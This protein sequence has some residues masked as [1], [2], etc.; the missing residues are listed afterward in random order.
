MFHIVEKGDTLRSIAERYGST[1][2]AMVA[3]NPALTDPDRIRPG[4]RLAIPD[5]DVAPPEPEA[6][7]SASAGTS[8]RTP[9]PA[10]PGSSAAGVRRGQPYTIEPGD[11]LGAIASRSGIDL[12]ELLIANPDI[13]DPDLV[14]PGQV[15]VIPRT[16]SA[17]SDAAD[18]GAPEAEPVAPR[19][20]TAHGGG[21]DW[22]RVPVEQRMLYAM[23]RLVGY[24]YP[25]NGAAGILGNLYAESGVIPNRVEGSSPATPMRAPDFAGTPQ[26]FT[27]E[28]IMR[29]DAEARRG[30]RLAGVGLAQWTYRPRRAGLFT[31]EYEGRAGGPDIL[32][33]MDAQIDYL[34]SELR[35]SYHRVEE[36]V[37]DPAVTVEDAADEI[38]Y[39][40]EIP[41]AIIADEERL[42]RSHPAV[43]EVFAERRIHGHRALRVW[44]EAHPR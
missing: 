12:G 7:P 2:T 10:P 11:T 42:P 31:H 29:R 5:A 43:Q 32:F 9:P 23:E 13:T 27:A 6:R 36:I 44:L 3:A 19:P 16:D 4:Q 33:D 26:T 41:G 25:V 1:V 28:E 30:P 24:G 38:L 40:F 21:R 34:V 17:A 37:S 22:R 39:Q 18:P 15:L 14:R 8:L 20:D 35:H